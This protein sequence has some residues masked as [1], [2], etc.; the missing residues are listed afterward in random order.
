MME[1]KLLFDLKTFQQLFSTAARIDQFKG[2]WKVI[3][4]KD[5]QYLKALK[6][7]ATI[8]SIG[9]STRIEGATHSNAEVES[10]LKNLKTTSFKTRE[11]QE[12]VGYFETLELILEQ[13]G[14]IEL[15]ESNIKTLHNQLLKYS[16]KDQRH[17]GAY[18]QFSNKVVAIYPDGTKR[19]LFNT[20]DPLQTP[21][22]MEQLVEWTNKELS[23]ENFHSLFVIGS[24]IYEF[25]SI[26]PFQDGN[27]RLSRLLT[28]LLLLRNGYDFVQYVSFENI[29]E[30]KK[31]A[32]YRSLISGQSQ[33]GT[34]QEI[35]NEWLLF[36]F[37]SLET[38]SQR[39]ESKYERYMNIGGYL[40]DR[41]QQVLAFIQKE[42]KVVFRDLAKQFPNIS[43]STIKRDLNILA[44]DGRIE[45]Q[46]AGR[47]MR[48]LIVQEDE[49]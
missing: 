11:E 41:Q 4:K 27:G 46:G 45:K 43:A 7:I 14:H 48:Y 49:L 28:S 37:Q 12:I 35:I 36:F 23:N 13:Y 42:K 30:E 1:N 18:K 20:T 19:V 26:H 22:E 9:S 8:Q 33:R 32:Y 2:K 44:N 39:L 16:E 38:L 3:E 34:D 40:N 47:G 10:L 31:S 5:H 17:K 25:L 21:I 24:F 6:A 29:I 15:S